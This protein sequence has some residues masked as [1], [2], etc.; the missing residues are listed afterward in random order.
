M[1]YRNAEEDTKFKPHLPRI[2][3]VS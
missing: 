1:E 2:S 3:K